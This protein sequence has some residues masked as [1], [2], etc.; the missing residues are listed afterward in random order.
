MF[1]Y[2][3]LIRFNEYNT[4]HLD[5]EFIILH[6]GTSTLYVLD[7]ISA[8]LFLSLGQEMS[9]VKLKNELIKNKIDTDLLDGRFNSEMHNL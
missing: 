1:N 9:R 6:L 8:Y 5:K 3:P 4:W 2:M 7:D